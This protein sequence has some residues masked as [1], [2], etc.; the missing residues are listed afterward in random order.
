LRELIVS[1]WE[2]QISS[3]EKDEFHTQAKELQQKYYAEM[4]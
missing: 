3:E 1:K 4:E 2:N